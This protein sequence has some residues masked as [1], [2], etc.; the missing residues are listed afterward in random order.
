MYTLI[1][2]ITSKKR[3]LYR[4]QRP[5]AAESPPMDTGIST[6][7]FQPHIF[8]PVNSALPYGEFSR[9]SRLT[10]VPP[11]SAITHRRGSYYILRQRSENTLDNRAHSKEPEVDPTIAN[12]T[13]KCRQELWTRTYMVQVWHKGFFRTQWSSSFFFFLYAVFFRLIVFKSKTLLFIS[14]TCR[15]LYKQ[16]KD[17]REN[18]DALITLHYD[19]VL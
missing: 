1:S 4:Q 10:N 19:A 16:K 7:Y 2:K 13:K 3:F 9:L 18:K 15:A 5:W 6:R 8:P 17:K 14:I 11:R 12:I